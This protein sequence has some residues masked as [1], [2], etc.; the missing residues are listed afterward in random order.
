M[1]LDEH[2]NENDVVVESQG[3]KIIYER[4]LEDF[5]KGAE[6]DYSDNWYNRGFSISS[7]STSSC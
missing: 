7:G 3:I 1:A 6:I 4:E 5:I 2:K